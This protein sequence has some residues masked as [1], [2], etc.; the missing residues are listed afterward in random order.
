MYNKCVMF[1][2]RDKLILILI[3]IIFL[4][5]IFFSLFKSMLLPLMYY[6]YHV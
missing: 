4:N 3:K 2:V 6:K 5:I 1:V